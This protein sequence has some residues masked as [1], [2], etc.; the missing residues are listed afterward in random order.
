MA[1]KRYLWY[2]DLILSALG[3]Y[4][5]DL[6]G[7]TFNPIELPPR[8]D[9]D[10]LGLDELSKRASGAGAAEWERECYLKVRMDICLSKV[11]VF[12]QVMKFRFLLIDRERQVRSLFI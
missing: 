9:M 4:L 2:T 12:I 7:N 8:L 11:N 10:R 1:L 6:L 3:T 5:G